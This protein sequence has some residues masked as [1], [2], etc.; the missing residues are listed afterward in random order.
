M[1][2]PTSENPPGS[3]VVCVCRVPCVNCSHRV[4]RLE[5][6]G[7]APALEMELWLTHSLSLCPLLSLCDVQGCLTITVVYPM[8][9]SGIKCLSVSLMFL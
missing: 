5:R 9:S 6:A 2:L 1:G 8:F 3:C 7:P 4:Q